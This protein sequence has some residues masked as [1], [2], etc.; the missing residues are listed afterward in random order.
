MIKTAIYWYLWIL[1]GHR[2]SSQ[3]GERFQEN[4][5]WCVRTFMLNIFIFLRGPIGLFWRVLLVSYYFQAGKCYSLSCVWLFQTPW[6]VARQAP[7]SMGFPRQENWSG[8]PLPSPGE[9][10]RPRDGTWVSCTTGRFL[11]DWARSK[12]T[13]HQFAALGVVGQDA[14]GSRMRERSRILREA[15]RLCPPQV[16]RHVSLMWRLL[17][18]WGRLEAEWLQVHQEGT[19]PCVCGEVLSKPQANY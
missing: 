11:T 16:W 10:S 8:L 15:R 13:D 1:R 6:T 4:T 19:S 7:L 12:Q 3:R 17:A 14:K 9:S 5:L 2:Q 18:G